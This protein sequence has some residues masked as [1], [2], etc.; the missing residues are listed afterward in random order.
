MY[1]QSPYI[2]IYTHTQ[3][4][5]VFIPPVLRRERVVVV[6]RPQDGALWRYPEYVYMLYV[7]IYIYI[8]RE[9]DLHIYIY[10]YIERERC[11]YIYIYIYTYIYIYMYYI[12]IY[13]YIYREREIDMNIYIQW[14]L[15]A[16]LSYH[17]QQLCTA[18]PGVLKMSTLSSSSMEGL[19]GA[20]RLSRNDNIDS[21]TIAMSISI[22]S[23]ISIIS[24]MSRNVVVSSICLSIISLLLCL[25]LLLLEVV[26]V[27]VAA[28]CR[29]GTTP[30]GESD[31]LCA[32]LHFQILQE[33]ERQM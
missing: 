13:I 25:C 30:R 14:C 2:Y 33:G 11:I 16:L 12:H 23:T 26:V 22:I 32:V 15:E 18:Y 7:H 20:F 29:E 9:R 3:C 5:H 27:V 17:Q 6:R 31:T 24:I 4:T 21:I 8:Q 10:I 28:A 19:A 1:L